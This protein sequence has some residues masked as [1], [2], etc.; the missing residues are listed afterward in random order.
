VWTPALVLALALAGGQA[1]ANAP[2]VL[3]AIRVQGNVASTDAEVQQL[4]GLEIGSLLAP[5]ATEEVAARLRA[6]KRFDKVDVLKRYASLTDP[7][8]IVLVIIVD[9]GPVRIVMTGD[10][11]HPTRVVRSHWP[12]V[13]FLP[14]LNTTDGYGLTYGVRLALPDLVGPHSRVAFPLTWG[15]DKRA[16]VEFDKTWERGPISRLVAAATI[17]STTN[18]FFDRDIERQRVGVRA[19]HDFRPTVRLGSVVAWQH[20]SFPDGVD[21]DSF[22]QVGADFVVDTRVDPLLA[23]NAVYLRAAWDRLALSSGGVNRTEFIGQAHISVGRPILVLRVLRDDS[24]KSVP[25]YL[26]PQLGGL[27]SVRGFPAGFAIGDTLLT[28]T[29]E[30]VVPLSTPFR[31]GTIGVSGFTDAGIVYNK[32]ERLGDQP[33]RQGV[34]GSVWLAA[35]FFRMS[36]AVAHGIGEGTRVNAGGSVSF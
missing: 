2:E 4:V 7:T 28:G 31:F 35:A 26:R 29:A 15:G 32:G 36:L 34:G 18:P 33:V 16:G 27:S 19:E 30:L 20:I 14:V 13:L 22:M 23:R 12:R 5:E 24:D 25:S 3:S 6:S 21:S 8:Q 9:E 1:P 10:P 17:A 11:D